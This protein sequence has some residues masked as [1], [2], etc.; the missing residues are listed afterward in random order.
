MEDVAVFGNVGGG[1]IAGQNHAV[2]GA[3]AAEFRVVR[4]A[5]LTFSLRKKRFL[6]IAMEVGEHRNPPEYEDLRLVKI[7]IETNQTID[8]T[9][10]FSGGA[11]KDV[12]HTRIPVGNRQ[13]D[14]GL[15]A[16]R[17]E[18]VA[19]AAEGFDVAREA[20]VV[21]NFFAQAAHVDVDRARGNEERLFADGVENLVAGEDATAVVGQ[22]LKNAE[23]AHGGEDGVA[24]NANGH[25]FGIDFQIGELHHTGV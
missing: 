13:C 8:I 19:E 12:A 22:K 9:I 20:R 23:F 24:A 10:A 3:A 25:R 4:L 2:G 5:E 6:L 7:V 15:P 16:W 21:F 1:G 17:V 14:R 18:A 11:G